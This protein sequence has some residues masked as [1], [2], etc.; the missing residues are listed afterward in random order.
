MTLL[1]DVITAYCVEDYNFFLFQSHQVMQNSI[2]AMSMTGRA[3]LSRQME[4]EVPV[5]VKSDNLQMK[6]KC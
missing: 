2:N 5:D 6:V 4:G 3:L 1:F